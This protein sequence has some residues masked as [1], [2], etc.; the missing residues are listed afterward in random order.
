MYE[1]KNFTARKYQDEITE[2]SKN[3]NTLTV[4]PTGTGKTSIA[5][6]TAIER[7][8]QHPHS[9]I[10]ILTP[11]KPLSAQ[12]LKEFKEKTN[13]P[14]DQIVLLTGETTPK[15]RQELWESA[16]I[17][18]A[19]PQTIQ[20]DLENERIST[21]VTSLLVVDECHRSRMNFANTIVAQK[22]MKQSK[23]PRIMALTASPGGT[24]E[25][26]DEIKNN[27]SIEAVEIRTEEDI[28]EFIQEKKITWL[29]VE[30]PEE[31]KKL[32]KFIK[33]AYEYK[34]HDLR[35][36][37]FTKPINL[38]SKGDLISL[39]KKFAILA[40]KRDPS[41]FYGLYITAVL[42][43]LDYAAELLETQG[44]SSLNEYWKKL[45]KETTK[46]AN[47]IKKMPEITAA[48]SLTNE[49]IQKNT[50]HPKIYML[51]GVIRKE[52]ERNPE[53]K[54]IVFAN[55]R[56]TIEEILKELSKLKNI[57]ASKLIG[58][59]L[60]LKQKDQI[61]TIRKFERGENNVLVCTQVGE[62]GIDIQS[63]AELA[64]FYDIVASEIRT[65]Q[66]KGRV[67]RTRTGRIVFLVTNK[68][69]EQGYKWSAY[70]KEKKMKQTLLNMKNKLKQD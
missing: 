64:I 33:I 50:K 53:A 29:E 67:G 59:K 7:L 42:I 24:K 44:I 41:A 48:I 60:G 2:T 6:L 38:I 36:L 27:L 46:A 63:G 69:R 35:K 65:I 13:I 39:Q 31:L 26:I 14:E 43:K 47:T 11:T 9:N 30:L 56:N 4:L 10:L 25:K 61:E 37:G 1:I 52:I 28:K 58:Q 55:Y 49:L 68:T 5:I 16:I 57:R 18:V 62:E 22:Y 54:I 32:L 40:R 8:K 20:K 21:S 15:K 19:T 45:D 23:F 34:L 17:A 12:I 66:R 70:N 51:K 3:N